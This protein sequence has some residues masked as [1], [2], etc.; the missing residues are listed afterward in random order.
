MDDGVEFDVNG[1][2]AGLARGFCRSRELG[3]L[4][5]LALCGSQSNIILTNILDLYRF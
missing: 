1:V 5:T 3:P 4:V 2:I